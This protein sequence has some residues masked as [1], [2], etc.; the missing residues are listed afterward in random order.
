ML[1]GISKLAQD[2]VHPPVET[3]GISDHSLHNAPFS[4]LLPARGQ[5]EESI[6]L[7]HNTYVVVS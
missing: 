2:K 6:I 3:G 5:N 7:M 4:A 1:L